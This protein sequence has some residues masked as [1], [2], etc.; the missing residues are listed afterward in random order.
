MSV[1]FERPV[2]EFP[3]PSNR[4]DPQAGEVVHCADKSAAAGF[5]H[6]MTKVTVI[7][8]DTTDRET[9]ISGQEGICVQWR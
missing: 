3:L 7:S 2:R 4:C 5:P 6:E 9:P 8:V 1:V